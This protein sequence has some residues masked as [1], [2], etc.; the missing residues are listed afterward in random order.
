MPA[1]FSQFINAP[2]LG[3]LGRLDRR[4]LLGPAQLDHPGSRVRLDRPVCLGHRVRPAPQARLAHR[5]RPG[6]P[7]RQAQGRQGQVRQARDDAQRLN[8]RVRWIAWSTASFGQL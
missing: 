6:H 1:V 2:D 8:V 4:G 7:G 3:V 5:V